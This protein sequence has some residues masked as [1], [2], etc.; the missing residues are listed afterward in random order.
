M[1]AALVL[2]HEGVLALLPDHAGVHEVL[3]DDCG[4]LVLLG[5]LLHLGQLLL[6]RFEPGHLGP[7][8]VLLLELRRLLLGDLYLG[9]AALGV[10]L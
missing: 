8:H 7:D 6:H 9:A 1:L 2:R 4:I 10:L 3:E 5:R